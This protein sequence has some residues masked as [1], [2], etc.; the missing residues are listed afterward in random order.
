MLI[1]SA[2]SVKFGNLYGHIVVKTTHQ[3][4]YFKKLNSKNFSTKDDSEKNITH[5]KNDVSCTLR[6][7]N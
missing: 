4:T 2:Y 7:I 3:I 1:L 6:A 5:D